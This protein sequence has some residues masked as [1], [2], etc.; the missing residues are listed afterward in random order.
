MHTDVF[1][2][3]ASLLPR[4][5]APAL[6]AFSALL[7]GCSSTAEQ[8]PA[9]DSAYQPYRSICVVT[10]GE[11]SPVLDIALMRTLRDRGFEPEFIKR[12]QTERARRCRVIVTFSSGSVNV[13][14]DTPAEMSLGFV[15]SY[16]GES[17]H[18]SVSRRHAGE[19]NSLFFGRPIPD[20]A[21]TI[22]HL[23]DRLFPERSESY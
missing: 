14:L 13:P 18:A 9:Y 17:Y 7:G 8:P 16:T 15:D 2:R 4:L 19:Q 10:E 23:V 21:V 3:P 6:I 20:P 11:H 12:G 1:S 5:T 22:R